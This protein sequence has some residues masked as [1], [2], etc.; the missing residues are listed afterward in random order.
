MNHSGLLGDMKPPSSSEVSSLFLTAGPAVAGPA[1]VI[2]ESDVGETEYATMQ[3]PII[4]AAKNPH[5]KAA[6]RAGL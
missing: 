6:A 1:L 4:V 3:T 2:V 5:K